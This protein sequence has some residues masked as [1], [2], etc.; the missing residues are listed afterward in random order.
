MQPMPSSLS[1]ADLDRLEEFLLSD[2]T[3]DDAMILTELHGYLTAVASGP[4][5]ILPSEWLPP[6]WGEAKFDTQEQAQAC[7][8]LVMSFYND[9]ANSLGAREPFEPLIDWRELPG[10]TELIPIVDDWCYGYMQGVALRGDAWAAHMKSDP[11][12]VLM[13]PMVAFGVFDDDE[14]KNPLTPQNEKD[15]REWTALIP[16]SAMGI[17]QYWR[18]QEKSARSTRAKP[19]TGRN[20]PCPC[21]SGNKYKKCHGAPEALH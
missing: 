11:L 7:T 10:R 19:K 21:G 12:R 9:I 18:E 14:R 17:Y 8:M 15:H 5:M 3:G 4:E 20:D 2:I 1:D 16:N 13:A 6:V